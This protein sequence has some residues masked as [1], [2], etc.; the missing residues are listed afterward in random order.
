[1]R[2]FLYVYCIATVGLLVPVFAENATL[3]D[4]A[5]AFAEAALPPPAPVADPP[6]S[7]VGRVSLTSRNVDLRNPG[8]AGWAD[9]EV[10]QPVFAGQALRTDS[11]SRA[12]V[13]IGANTVDLSGDTEIELASL[14]NQYVQIAMSRGRLAVRLHELGNGKAV[15]VDFPQGGVWLLAPGLYDI[16][17]GSGDQLPKVTVFEGQAK[18]AG[19][20]GATHLESDQTLVLTDAPP[21]ATEAAVPDLF[22]EWCQERDYDETRLAA[23]YYISPDVTGFADLDAAGIWRV[24][25][26]YGPVWFPTGP[27]DWAPY[28]FGHWRWIAPWGWTW[29]DDQSWGFAPSHYG[30]WTLINEHWAWVP[31]NFI[32]RPLYSPAV[33]AFLGTPGVGLSSE[34]GA[35]VAWFPLAPGEAYWP[36]YT[37]DVDYV[38]RLNF[39]NVADLTS[40]GMQADGEPPLEVFNEDFANRQFA[41]VVPRS[42]FTNGRPVAPARVILPEKRLQDAPVLMASPQIAPAAP[43][44]RVARAAPNPLPTRVAVNPAHKARARSILGAS[45]QPRGHVQSVII[46]GAHLHVPS[47]AGQPRGRQTIMLRIA[48]SRGVPG[49]RG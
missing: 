4:E 45:L 7:R 28:R 41:T 21:L 46:R 1:M 33:V 3:P 42:I 25:P 30:R 8:Q 5:A 17:A 49:K 35:T 44:Q 11:R 43:V 6:P 16:D 12:E 37:R 29:I 19:D 20:S 31:G 27:E 38:R 26:E 18:F 23:L 13:Q 32:E 24:N 15:E 48:H 9:A 39:G 10:N 34:D 36:S 40:I 2:F 22:I 14:S 47:Y